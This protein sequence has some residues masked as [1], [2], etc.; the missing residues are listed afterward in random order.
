M[1]ITRKNNTTNY[2]LDL[3]CLIDSCLK[4]NRDERPNIKQIILKL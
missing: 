2:C 1:V 4:F 3:L